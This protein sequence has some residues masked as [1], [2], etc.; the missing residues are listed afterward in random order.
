MKIVPFALALLLP[1]CAGAQ[2][3]VAPE[4]EHA[5]RKLMQMTGAMEMGLQ[6]SSRLFEQLKHAYPQVPEEVWQELLAELN[7]ASALTD[8]VIPIYDRH[9]SLAEL[10]ALVEFYE[11]PLGRRVVQATPL[12]AQESMVAGQH[13]GQLQAQRVIQ[14][15]QAR[16]YTQQL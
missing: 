7:D 9:Y 14:R 1:L 3:T 2:G 4:K 15:L 5:I 11:S 6:L 8:L 10:Q 12:I 13:W 16:G